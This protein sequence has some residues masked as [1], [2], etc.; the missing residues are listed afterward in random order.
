MERGISRRQLL[1]G[2]AAL[3]GWGSSAIPA[4]GLPALEEDEEL[5]PF[6]DFPADFNPNPRPGVRYLDTRKIQ[7]FL[8]PSDQFFTVQH[9]G[10]PAVDPAGYRLRISG[11]V[12]FP[13][14]LSLGELRH[15]PRSAHTAGFECS[16]NSR[17]RI[18]PL[19]GNARWSGVSL[20]H[21]LREAGIR[22]TAREVVFWGGGPGNGESLPWRRHG[23][24]GTALRKKFGPG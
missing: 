8:T 2:S 13:G 7:S 16:G 1:R 20:S 22:S 14:E 15:R 5:V 9:Y 10:R 12:D 18:N 19:V 3:A 21:L 4:L 11:L 17:R 6:T 23:H 24:G